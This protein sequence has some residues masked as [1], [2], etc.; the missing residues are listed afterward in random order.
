MACAREEFF[1]LQ[2]SRTLSYI[3]WLLSRFIPVIVPD[4]A[5]NITLC[6]IQTRNKS[7]HVSGYKGSIEIRE[8]LQ[9]GIARTSP[10]VTKRYKNHVCIFYILLLHC[11]TTLPCY[12]IETH[13]MPLYYSTI[14]LFYYIRVSELA[15][16][17]TILHWQT[18]QKYGRKAMKQNWSSEW[19]KLI[20]K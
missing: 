16:Y 3:S 10:H 6:Y 13:K 14:A 7:W 11:Y 17:T 20:V 19:P 9:I 15:K 2:I 5:N 8:F 1:F 4:G 12:D 18:E